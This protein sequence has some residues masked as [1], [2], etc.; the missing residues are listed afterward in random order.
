MKHVYEGK[1]KSVYE[2]E[3]GNYLLKLKDDVTGEDGQIDPGANSVI[4]ELEGMGKASLRMSRYFFE[5]LN[6]A[7]IP[8]HYIDSNIEENTM[9]VKPAKFFGE[10]LEVICR[11]KAWGSF[12]KRYGKYV[13]KGQDLNA[14]VEIT[15]KD[16][17]RG[18]PLITE[19]A[20]E[21]LNLLSI[22]E[23]NYLKEITRKIATIIK[24]D[25]QAKGLELYDI[26]FE[27]GKV[28][29]NITLIDDISG[30]NMRVFKAEEQIDPLDLAKIVVK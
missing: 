29:N 8:T 18:D 26:K 30:A 25:L 16:D 15:L 11:F 13:E 3:D 6:Q 7:G 28:N 23:Y 9:T 2:L 27:Y 12:V 20:L 5:K 10:G 19:E 17:D 24:E 4:G 21:Q 14:L 1:T 22:I